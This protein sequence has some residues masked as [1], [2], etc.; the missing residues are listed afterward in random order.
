MTYDFPPLVTDYSVEWD[1]SLPGHF[2]GP[3]EHFEHGWI[4]L[5]NG[6]IL[7]VLRLRRLATEENEEFVSAGFEEGLWEVGLMKEAGPYARLMGMEGEPAPE[8]QFIADEFNAS[9]NAFM[10]VIGGLDSEGVNRVLARLAEQPP[11]SGEDPWQPPLFDIAEVVREFVVIDGE[12]SA[13][14]G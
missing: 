8:V 13:D 14:E 3:G 6:Y 4:R 7:S 11:A 9:E 2:E 12:G 10:G 1:T 5:D